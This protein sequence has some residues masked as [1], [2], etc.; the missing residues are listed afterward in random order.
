MKIGIDIG[1]SHLA[2]GLINE[3]LKIV[4]KI[5]ETYTLEEKKDLPKTIIEKMIFSAMLF[6]LN[7]KNH[8]FLFKNNISF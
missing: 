7:R 8:F 6:L 5:D 2:V 4:D 3:E 1:G